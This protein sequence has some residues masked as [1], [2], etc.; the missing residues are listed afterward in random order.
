MIRG[1][2]EVADILGETAIAGGVPEVLSVALVGG[3]AA[4]KKGNQSVNKY[5]I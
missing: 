2:V 5:N 1:L 4:V 3:V